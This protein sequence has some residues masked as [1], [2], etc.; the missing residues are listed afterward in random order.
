MD[1]KGEVLKSSFVVHVGIMAR[2][3]IWK[4]PPCRLNMV[5][6]NGRWH[7]EALMATEDASEE[8]LAGLA[9]AMVSVL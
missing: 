8:R 3:R 1:T 9:W 5:W 2:E 6:L 4:A 7:Y